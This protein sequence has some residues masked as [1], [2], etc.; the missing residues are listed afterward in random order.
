MIKGFTLSAGIFVFFLTGNLATIGAQTPATYT[1]ERAQSLIRSGHRDLALKLLEDHLAI[2]P[3]DS[4]ARVLRGTILSWDGRYEES[5]Y[6]LELVLSQTAGYADAITPLLNVYMWSHHPERAELLARRKLERDPR[7]GALIVALAKSL[8]AM[9]Q[10]NEAA[11]VIRR[12]TPADLAN[13][14]TR[15][16][17]QKLSEERQT[18]AFTFTHASDWFSGGATPGREDQIALASETGA[19]SLIGR[20]SQAERFSINSQQ[21]EVEFYPHLNSRTYAYLDAGFS[22]DA[23]LY[24]HYRAGVDLFRNAG[25]GVEVSGGYRR[26]AFGTG[27]NIY[28]GGLSK[29]QGNWLISSRFY[30]T[31]G[32][33]TS[34]SVQLSLRRYFAG[35]DYVSFLGGWGSSSVEISSRADIGILRSAS[36][37][38]GVNHRLNGRLSITGNG[39]IAREDRI[40]NAGIYHYTVDVT[41]HF[42]F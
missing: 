10:I 16:F 27:V 17:S 12:L 7:N 34:T 41:L 15:E 11:L 20:F 9:H 23:R 18:R 31:P 13:T 26:L 30:V 39:G 14:Q 8:E 38:G 40:N 32:I 4:E 22:M 5:R 2:E 6:E 36:F 21:T 33:G 19:G 29:Y 3:S 42:H 24:P 37:G 1:F 35:S 28:T 25:H